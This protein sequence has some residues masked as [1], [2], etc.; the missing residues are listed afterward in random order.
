[1]GACVRLFAGVVVLTSMPSLS[2]YVCVRACVSWCGCSD[3]HGSTQDNETLLGVGK[4]QLSLR[5]YAHLHGSDMAKRLMVGH[6]HK[7]IH[8]HV[9]RHT[10]SYI[11]THIHIFIDG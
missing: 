3:V 7:I 9:D 6:I 5:E 10:I 1:M 4:Q 11:H 8:N 2:V